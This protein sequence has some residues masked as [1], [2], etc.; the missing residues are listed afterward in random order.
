MFFHVE[1]NLTKIYNNYLKAHSECIAL[2]PNAIYLRM[3][4]DGVITQ[5]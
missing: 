4:E 5:E 2:T 3:K 1:G